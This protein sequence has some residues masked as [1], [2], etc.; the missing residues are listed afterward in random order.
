MTRSVVCMV[1]R[2][3]C[4][5]ERGACMVESAVC[6]IESAVCIVVPA[7]LSPGVPNGTHFAE[8]KKNRKHCMYGKKKAECM[9]ETINLIPNIMDE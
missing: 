9:V 4:M 2:A 7:G 6:M 1:E 3:V 5:V 8:K